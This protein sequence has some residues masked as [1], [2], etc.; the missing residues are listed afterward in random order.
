MRENLKMFIMKNFRNPYV[1]L[2]LSLFI[3]ITSC[4]EQSD[5]NPNGIDSKLLSKTISEHLLITEN[6]SKLLLKEKNVDFKKL[7]NFPNF[8]NNTSDL[9]KS[10]KDANFKNEEEISILFIKLSENLENFLI[11]IENI[12]SYSQTELE[13]LLITEIKSQFALKN[14]KTSKYSLKA[15]NCESALNEVSENCG[16]NY[17]IS[18]A[19]VVA[20]GFITFGWGTVLGYAAATGIMVKCH[21]DASAAYRTCIAN[22]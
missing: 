6:L 20:S 1:S 9:K 12:E 13:N 16:E 14:K 21:E 15:G 3:L 7:N 19:V 5:F 2:V 22:Q 8:F 10:L 18:V 17:A 11:S 4:S